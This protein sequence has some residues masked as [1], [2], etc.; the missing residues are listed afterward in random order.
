M[1]TDGE[2]SGKGPR[3]GVLS[4]PL[5]RKSLQRALFSPPRVMGNEG[6]TFYSLASAHKCILKPGGGTAPA[7]GRPRLTAVA[8]EPSH[9]H[10]RRE[11]SEPTPACAPPGPALVLP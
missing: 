2:T 5:Y 3:Q 6:D 8:G 1:N 4:G 9:T 10:P 7:H 11:A